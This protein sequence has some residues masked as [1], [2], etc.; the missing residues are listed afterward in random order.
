MT[1]VVPRRV[2]TMFSKLLS[3]VTDGLLREG[4]EEYDRCFYEVN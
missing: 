1:V 3:T 2:Q 4:G